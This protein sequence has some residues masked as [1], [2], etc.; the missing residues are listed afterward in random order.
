M[1]ARAVPPSARRALRA[2]GALACAVAL[3][4]AGCSAHDP[5]QPSATASV[6]ASDQAVATADPTR[7]PPPGT[8]DAAVLAAR[9]AK[10]AQGRSAHVSLTAQ[11][12]S[13]ALTGAGL[14][15]YGDAPVMAWRVQGSGGAMRMVFAGGAMYLKAPGMP[16]TKWIKVSPTGSDPMSQA[17]VP[18]LDQVGSAGA[19]SQ[20]LARY[21]GV[22]VL[23][24]AASTLDGVKVRKYTF[25]VGE[26]T[27]VA[28]ASPALR[29]L[30]AA[31]YA[32]ARAS[33]ALW[34][35]GA[36]LVRKAVIRVTTPDGTS[37][38]TVRWTHWGEPVAITL[39]AAAKTVDAATLKIA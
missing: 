2:A 5:V 6:A 22:P 8:V 36:G 23:P 20:T 28:A 1:P 30:A 27:L 9:T 10:A 3:A 16:T 11:G 4:V 26:K 24:G 31:R 13:G 33:T 34:L 18:M 12:P 21:A 15:R 37:K 19:V 29:D 38:T 39:P 14:A 25:T 32:G 17:L 35:D 7:P